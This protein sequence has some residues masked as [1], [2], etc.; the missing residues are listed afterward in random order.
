MGNDD[1]LKLKALL[2]YWA[3]HNREHSQE[4]REWAER[5]RTMGETDI[6]TGLS[7]AAGAMDEAGKLID[8]A[9][10]RLEER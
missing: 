9:L 4:F 2:G 10:A 1:R 7:Q 8:R 5:A 3:E 6:S